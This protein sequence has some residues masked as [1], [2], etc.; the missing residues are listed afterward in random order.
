MGLVDHAK[1]TRLNLPTSIHEILTSDQLAEIR[2]NLAVREIQR[3]MRK[4]AMSDQAVVR[5]SAM[6]GTMN[7]RSIVNAVQEA[8]RKQ[9]Q[10]KEKM[11]ELS[12]AGAGS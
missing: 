3:E 11:R 10:P 6:M 4:Q 9:T 7:R 12:D 8:V 2:E 5:S 1:A